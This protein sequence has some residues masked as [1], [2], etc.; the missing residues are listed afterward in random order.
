MLMN[1]NASPEDSTP[2]PGITGVIPQWL[3][4][5]PH[6]QTTPETAGG[7]ATIFAPD[8]PF[9][10]AGQFFGGFVEHPTD[11]WQGLETMAQES[12]GLLNPGIKTT[13]ELGTGRSS[14]TGAP[15][16]RSPSAVASSLVPFAR[17][18]TSDM[19]RLPEKQSPK[20][21]INIGGKKV[22][23]PENWLNYLTGAGMRSISPQR[24]KGELL[25]QK[26]LIDAQTKANIAAE[27]A[28]AKKEYGG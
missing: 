15:I 18:A 26:D 7:N 10:Q 14:L 24:I 28:K 21:T 19:G 5:V 27:R 9:G 1:P 4:D 22:D 6:I 11:P 13:Y 3:R 23:I 12:T 8:M 17:V 2:L 20:F 16:D 25:R